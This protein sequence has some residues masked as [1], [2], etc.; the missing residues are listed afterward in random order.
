M[1]INYLKLILFPLMFLSLTAFSQTKQV[2]GIVTDNNGNI[3]PGVSVVVKGTTQGTVTDIDGT[4]TMKDLSANTV[5]VF[6]FIG[7]QSKEIQVIDQ[8]TINIALTTADIDLDEVVVIG[9]G[10]IKKSDLTGAVSSIK[11]EDLEYGASNSL[12]NKIGGKI[13]GLYSVQTNGKPGSASTI[14]IRGTNSI[15]GNNE[16]LF[17]I[18]GIPFA[19]S[20]GNDINPDDIASVEVLKDASSTAIYG[21]RG[22]NGV[23]LITTKQG[24]KGEATVKFNSYYGFADLSKKIDV[25]NAEEIAEVHRRATEN[26]YTRLFDPDTISGAGTDWQDELYRRATLQNYQLSVSGGSDNTNYYISANYMDEE[27]IALNSGSQRYSL[28]TN[29]DTKVSDRLN[30]TTNIGVSRRAIYG[31]THIRDALVSN[32]IYPLID[33]ESGTYTV[34][35]HPRGLSGNA[36]GSALL[37]IR[38][39]NMDKI[40]SNIT[41]AYEIFEGLTARV[42]FGAII[43]DIKSNVFSSAGTYQGIGDINASINSI[44]NVFWNNN[45]T[46][47]YV[48]EFANQHSLNAMVGFTLEKS[49]HEMVNAGSSAF[50]TGFQ[51]YHALQAGT[52]RNNSSALYENQLASFISRL[53]YNIQDKYLFTLSGRYDGSSRF[54]PENRWALFPSAAFAWRLSNEDFLKDNSTINNLKLRL[55]A[56]LSG[57]QG[58]GNYQTLSSLTTTSSLYAGDTYR[59]GYVT[60]RLGNNNLQWEK[61]QQYDFGI[62]LGLWNNRVSLIADVYYKKTTDLLY[63]KALPLTTGFSSVLSNIGSMENK[64]IEL[65]L[66]TNNLSGEFK[67]QTNFNIAANRNK[68][69]DLGVDADGSD[70]TR[71]ISP[72]GSVGKRV[73]L[74]D[75]TAL[76]EGE[77]IGGAFGY[78]YDGTYK[79]EEEIEAG[80]EPRKEPGDAKFLDLNGDGELDP[81]DRQMISNP[82]PDFM[83]GLI[84][85][86][87]Y[88]G[89]DLRV[90]L[91]FVYGNEIF[92]YTK[93]DL[94][95]IEGNYNSGQWAMDSW[96]PDNPDSDIPRAA[97]SVRDKGINTFFVEDGSYLRFKNITLGYNLPVQKWNIRKMRLYVSMDNLLTFTKYSGYNP[98]V[99]AFGTNTISSGF[100]NPNVYPLAK[101]V[102]FGLDINF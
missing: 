91:Q 95:Y 19:T 69:L 79:T 68:I 39:N 28:R 67:W 33:N 23:I 47:T 46:L 15:I 38:E 60:N 101:T 71:I 70:I 98:D 63:Q 73:Y 57:E 56:G 72:E 52:Y 80:L 17:V 92:S 94:A 42:N 59:I 31:D 82:N 22:A 29:V 74:S 27:G 3:L 77:P 88:K 87:S 49:R 54:N 58:I 13:P 30:I 34:Y 100:D 21:T 9:Y 32:P 53:N 66:I 1:K 6:S 45:N 102:L 99:S 25:L 65:N 10:T 51:E 86:F 84:N 35:A 81:E 75:L 37:N 93:F 7:M 16:P 44:N 36:V 26:G 97:W 20:M 83:G 8:S 90:F 76:I 12:S 4:Y 48:K 14:R 78:V 5:L 89:F 2:S 24:K 62:D 18:D 85:E 41:G 11:S 64:G 96:S 61:T 43:T 50:L 55:S 40:V